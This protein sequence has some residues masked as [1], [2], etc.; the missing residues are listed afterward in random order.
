M[1]KTTSSKNRTQK[2]ILT[3]VILGLIYLPFSIIVSLVK[4][5]K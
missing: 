2:N 5:K 3:A 4:S 1:K